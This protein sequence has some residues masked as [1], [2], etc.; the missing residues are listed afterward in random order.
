MAN[1]MTTLDEATARDL[2]DKYLA[3]TQDCQCALTT[4]SHETLG[5]WSFNWNSREAVDSHGKQGYRRNLG[6]ILVEKRTR[7]V[8]LLPFTPGG[9]WGLYCCEARLTREL[10]AA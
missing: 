2:C 10:A 9:G 3:A 4:Y 6:P 5:F 1:V 8:T 7:I